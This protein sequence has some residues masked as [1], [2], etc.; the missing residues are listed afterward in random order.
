MSTNTCGQTCGPVSLQNVFLHVTKACNLNCSYCYFSAKKPMRDEMT[1]VEF[2]RL[3]PQLVALRPRKIVLTGGEPLLR[4]DILDLLSGMRDA[5]PEHHVLRCLNTN[6]HRVTA[7]LAQQL[8]GLADEVRVSL[9][10]LPERNDAL[11]G[12]GNFEAAFR[13]LKIFYNAGFEPKVL[14]TI[15][16][17]NLP[18]LEDLICLL[19]ENHFT[20]ISLINFR[21][22]G[23]G[24]GNW[25]WRADP[26]LVRAALSRAWHRC[27]PGQPSSAGSH[28]VDQ[29]QSHC[30]VGRFL[31]I[32]PNG[33]VFPCHV[34]TSAEF[35]C[36]NVREQSLS[37]ICQT[38]GLLGQLASLDFRL[39]AR[40]DEKLLEVSR[41]G[42]CMGNVYALTRSSPIWRSSLRSLGI[43]DS[44]D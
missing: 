26:E 9:D 29:E 24:E 14:V 5:D 6:G 33:D 38:T 3:W 16:A 13:A 11:R 37:D 10:G 34:L 32:L 19:V 20:R 27:Y 36:G 30:G 22:I 17:A 28:N 31:N 42:A 41:P 15:T 21:P 7:D 40:A 2:E 44:S 4:P 18:D 39:L 8:V 43:E 12:S 35:R 23:R 1:T 25:E